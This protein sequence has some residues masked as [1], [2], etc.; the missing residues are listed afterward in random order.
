L[1]VDVE[2]K[3]VPATVNV[4]A[5]PPAAWFLPETA[6]F[7]TV[8]T[9][10]LTVKVAGTEGPTDGAGLVTVTSTLPAVAMSAAGTVT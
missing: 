10:L 4:N 8:G 1:T 5:V 9:G 3:F 7:V 2:T 6:A